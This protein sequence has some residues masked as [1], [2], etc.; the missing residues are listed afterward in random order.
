MPG[1]RN[2]ARRNMSKRFLIL[3]GLL[4]S[5]AAALPAQAQ[6]PFRV[7]TTSA[8]FLEIGFGTAGAAMGDAYVAVVKDLSALYWNPAGLAYMEQSEAQ[9]LVQPW[10]AD[11][12][13]SFAGVGLKLPSIGTLAFGVFHT[14]FG[15][16]E[17]TTVR[18]QDGTGELFNANDFAFSLAYG[19]RLA[20]W[21]GFGAAVKYI[22]SQI[23][24]LNASAVAV[25]LGVIV[26]THFFSPTGNRADGMTIAMSI[27][28]Y[29][30]RMQYDGIDLVNPI[31]ILPDE[32]GNFRDVPGQFRLNSWELPL[33]F[34]LG[35]A[36]HPIVSGSSRFTLAAD[37]L[38][39]N[40]NSESVNFGAQYELN[41]PTAGKFYLR[42]GYRAAFLE[43]SEFGITL[44]G[45]M[46]LRMMHNVALKIDYAYR[47]VGLLGRV[48]AYSFGVMF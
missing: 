41:I 4:I 25:D 8:N 33:I 34:R 18:D 42:G 5:L 29:G 36:I 47:D 23:W 30:T 45:G 6:K 43:D 15:D 20:Q 9:F 7:G 44:G 48:H 12:S 10:V 19:R 17:V 16:M 2:L 21:F 28:N 31:D 11:I 22:S 14:G 3:F 38:H 32:N 39:P 1:K 35:V 24:H 46:L 26:N 40:D 13:T 27:S 37:A